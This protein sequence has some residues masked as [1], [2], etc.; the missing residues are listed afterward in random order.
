MWSS[1]GCSQSARFEISGGS[2]VLCIAAFIMAPNSCANPVLCLCLFVMLFSTGASFAQTGQSAVRR[3]LAPPPVDLTKI[4]HI[5]F[6][7]KENRTFD[8]YFGTYPGADGATTAK[9]STGQTIPLGHTPDQTPRDI[10]GHG[11]YDAIAGTDKGS[12]DQFDLIPGASLNGDMLGLSQLTQQDIPN[13]FAYAQNFV[14]ADKMY[15][16]MKG[17]SWANHLYMVG[18]QAGGA[19]TI[20]K[21]TVNSWGCDANPTASV[22]VWDTDDTVSAPFPCFDFQ[23]MADELQAAGSPGNSTRRPKATLH[24]CTLRSMASAIF[25]LGHCGARMW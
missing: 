21:T 23:T 3:H 15:S 6:I 22:Q 25:V 14:L 1:A 10:A 9:I 16:S 11:W 4:Q 20:P 24:M 13:Y 8:N 19:F 12:M 18:A 2:L 7:I 17:A 5:I